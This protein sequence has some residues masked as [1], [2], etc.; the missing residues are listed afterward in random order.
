MLSARQAAFIGVG[1]MVGAGIFSL[2]GAAGE[3]A[4]SA[5]W[6]SFVIAGIVAGLQGYSFARMG[7]RF[8]SAGGLLEYVAR[9]Y[10]NGHVTGVIGWLLLAV[11][12]IIT[13]MVAVSFGSYAGEIFADGGVVVDM[14]EYHAKV[15]FLFDV[16]GTVATVD[17]L[18]DLGQDPATLPKRQDKVIRFLAK[19]EKTPSRSSTWCSPKT[20]IAALP[21]RLDARRKRDPSCGRATD[22][23]GRC[24]QCL[25][26]AEQE[27][28][29]GPRRHAAGRNKTSCRA[30]Y[31][32]LV[33]SLLAGTNIGGSALQVA[34]LEGNSYLQAIIIVS[35]GQSNLG[36]DEAAATSSSP[37][38]AAPK[39]KIPVFTVGVGEYRQPAS[40]RIDDLQAPEIARPDD[41]F[42][43][44]VPV[45]GTGLGD[46][47]FDVTLEA[48]RVKDAPGQP[49]DG[50]KT[51]QLGP[52]RGQVQGRR[53]SSAGHRRVRDRRAGAQG[54]QG[55]RTTRTATSKATWQFVAKVPRH[56]REPF[57]KAE[58]VS[59]PPTEVLV[60]KQKL[61]VLLFAGG[62]TREYQFVRTI[63]YREVLEKRIELSVLLQ[64]GREDHV[65]QDVE[66]SACSQ[67]SPTA[68][69]RRP[70]R[71][72]S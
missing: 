28:L 60:Q 48:T 71:K 29:Q 61:R 32:D 2:L 51:Y 68:R 6:I 72:V 13:A 33:D 24:S 70:G 12:A 27:Q 41:K 18:P 64:T 56:P 66:A 44:R 50:E 22:A 65:D 31:Q 38:S 15:L 1:A 59:D 69:R 8:P 5:V 17:D 30:K 7:A 63:L 26:Q 58:H 34:K 11:N 14:S 54:H 67:T 55:R 19:A 52:K 4:G 36:S 53:R 43:V 42:P 23:D 62:P 47:E 49:V 35:D 21:L 37:A 46:E 9:G 57:P 45:V 20:P 25:A 40:I 3:V 16:S 39:R 10:G